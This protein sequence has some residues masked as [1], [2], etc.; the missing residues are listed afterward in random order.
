MTPSAIAVKV[1]AIRIRRN[2]W[3]TALSLV[4][5]AL[6]PLAAAFGVITGAPWGMA[7]PYLAVLGGIAF[8]RTWNKRPR[9]RHDAIDV[10]VDAATLRIGDRVVPRTTVTRAELVP[11]PPNAIV[12]VGVRNR[13]GEEL[14]LDDEAAAHRL[15]MALGY[16]ASQTTA[17]YRLR[18]L[19]LVR[20][21]FAPFWLIPFVVLGGHTHAAALAAAFPLIV[22]LMAVLYF[23]PAKLVVGVDGLLL[24]WLWVR[25]FISTSDIAAVTRFESGS[26]RNR[27]Q[28]VEVTTRDGSVRLPVAGSWQDDAACAVIERRIEDARALARG[29]AHVADDALLLSRGETAMRDWIGRLKALGAGATA[30]LRTAAVPPEHLWRV[31]DDP[32]QPALKRAAAAVALGPTLDESG[33]VRLAEIARSTAAPKLRIALERASEDA[34]DEQLEEALAQIERAS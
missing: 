6:I 33:R 25:K 12:R 14:V 9:A 26:Q 21:R 20:Y 7:I 27:V 22:A 4:P 3:L 8:L 16:D 15:L 19:A 34:P 23:V 29:A 11:R 5:F 13:P 17:T 30:T 32:A 24:R 1:E 2:P 28:G 18:S 31:A 10:E